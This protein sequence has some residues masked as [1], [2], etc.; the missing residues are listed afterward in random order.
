MRTDPL[1][2]TVRLSS[3][4]V[5]LSCAGELDIATVGRLEEALE[6][7]VDKRP[8]ALVLD[9]SEVTFLGSEGLRTIARAATASEQ[10]GVE[11][12]LILNDKIRRVVELTGLQDRLPIVD[13][14][15]PQPVGR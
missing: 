4:A 1:R 9:L 12:R 7:W 14:E 8:D 5:L 6:L 13:A 2:I 3:S 10:T 11:L 15:P